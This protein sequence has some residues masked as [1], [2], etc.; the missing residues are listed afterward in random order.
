M[1]SIEPDGTPTHRGPQGLPGL[2]G[3]KGDRGEQGVKGDPGLRGDRGLTGDKGDP[4]DRGVQ[5]EPGAR[6]AG[7]PVLVS[8]Q[9]DIEIATVVPGTV[10]GL[11]LSV[12]AGVAYWFRYMLA[13]EADNAQPILNV[14]APTYAT[15]SARS[16]IDQSLRII[17]GIIVPTA[18][19]TLSIVGSRKGV[20]T[21]TIKHGSFGALYQ[22]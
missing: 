2:K 20:G 18:A 13:V 8:V 11:T 7:N 14:E 6:G 5:G 9:A 17:E 10:D 16:Q 15:L 19:G 22:V 4:G 3:E 21:V 1:S 12:A